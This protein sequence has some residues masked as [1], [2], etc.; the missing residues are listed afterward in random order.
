MY[1]S[2]LYKAMWVNNL[3]KVATQWNSG[4]TRDSNPGHRARIPSA[5]TIRPLSQWMYV[6]SN[7]V[8]GWARSRV[9]RVWSAADGA[10]WRRPWSVYVGCCHNSPHCTQ[11]CLQWCWPRQ[12]ADINA[13]SA[14]LC[15]ALQAPAWPRCCH[16]D[17][18][19][20]CCSRCLCEKCAW[21]HSGKGDEVFILSTQGPN[22]QNFVKWTF[23]ILSQL[24]LS[25]VS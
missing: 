17:R 14:A 21:S 2:A 19:D 25:Y 10:W 22:L 7:H 20:R 6:C 1:Y 8:V 24:S 4:A 11:S 12:W 15:S 5:L 23:V 13:P 18:S 3:P 16:G 9:W